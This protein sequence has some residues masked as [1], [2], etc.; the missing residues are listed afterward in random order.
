MVN[1][2]TV[3]ERVEWTDLEPYFLSNWGWPEGKWGPEHVAITGPTGSGK[4][5]FYTHV[6]HQRAIRGGAHCVILATK[7][8]DA[9]LKRLTTKEMGWKLKTTWPPE[10]GENRVIY[11]PRSGKPG[12]GVARQR[13][14][15]A[16]MLDEMWKP[17][18]NVIVAFD[19]IA[20]VEEELR[21]RSWI[22]KYWRESR[23]LGLTIVA[24][25]QRPRGV[26]RYMHSEP[27]WSVAFKPQDLDD[28][29]RVAEILGN[30]E[31]IPDIMELQRREFILCKK[32]TGEAYISQ[33]KV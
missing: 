19:E 32:A 28:M 23:T 4:S 33:L 3:L 8:A 10:Y 15:V 5:F 16:N 14:A 18:A 7:P 31:F 9:T 22:T 26:S 27:S 1:K 29:R 11:W 30:R 6:L 20:Y 13:Q 17:D 12:E 24:T 21:L 2:P 25:T